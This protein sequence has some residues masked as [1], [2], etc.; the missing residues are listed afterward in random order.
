M[1]IRFLFLIILI[2]TTIQ[3]TSHTETQSQVAIPE[4]KQTTDTIATPKKK[5]RPITPLKQIEIPRQ[6]TLAFFKNLFPEIPLPYSLDQ[7]QIENSI[8][9]T[10][11]IDTFLVKK[12]FIDSVADND[13]GLF[14][15]Y[16]YYPVGL[17]NLKNGK[18]AVIILSRGGAGG[19]EDRY[20][21][22]SF[23]S[24]GKKTDQLLI[25]QA[26]ADCSFEDLIT[27]RIDTNANIY[28]LHQRYTINCETEKAK[29]TLS[30]NESVIP[31]IISSD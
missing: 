10:N 11:A 16:R 24:T 20:Y 3:C 8:S 28:L 23:L 13:N 12:Y 31:K 1:V 7:Q 6:D 27:S 9:Y 2:S 19:Q 14:I 22:L 5:V 18:F 15:R 4:T 21:F 25:G 30:Q 29:L 26:I 17:F